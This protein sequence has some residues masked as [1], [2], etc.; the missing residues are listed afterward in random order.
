MPLVRSLSRSTDVVESTVGEPGRLAHN[1]TS[2]ARTDTKLVALCGGTTHFGH[3]ECYLFGCIF[4]VLVISPSMLD[5]Y[6]LFS[7]PLLTASGEV[8]V[9]V[10]NTARIVSKDDPVGER[11][12][13]YVDLFCPVV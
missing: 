7:T 8:S 6:S 2:K 3:R 1:A 12:C 4:S 10:L 5:I 11:G 13:E 9:V